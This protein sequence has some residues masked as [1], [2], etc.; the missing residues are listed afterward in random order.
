MLEQ[1]R[2]NCTRKISANLVPFSVKINF[3]TDQSA[4]NQRH[5]S[6]LVGTSETT[7][8]APFFIEWVKI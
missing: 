2:E 6:S 4:G 7:R 8:E 5:E 3:L 1:F